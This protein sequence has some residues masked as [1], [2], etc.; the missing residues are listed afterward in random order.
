M[1]WLRLW[2]ESLR[3]RVK[4]IAVPHSLAETTEEEAAAAALSDCDRH[5][6]SLPPVDPKLLRPQSGS[7]SESSDEDSPSQEVS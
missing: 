1:H 3:A 6:D 2:A 5:F 4:R 7:E